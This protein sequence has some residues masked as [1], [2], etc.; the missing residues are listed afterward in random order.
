MALK[1]E[2]TKYSIFGKYDFLEATPENISKL[3]EIFGKE[4]FLPNMV[5]MIQIEQP[6]NIVKQVARP[7]FIN[8]AL[9]CSI[10]FL[11]DRIDIEEKG[12]LS[13]DQVVDY[14]NQ[15]IIAFELKIQRLAMNTGAMWSNLNSEDMEKLKKSFVASQAYPYVNDLIEWSSRNV[16]RQHWKGSIDEQINVGQNIQNIVEIV[17]GV[18]SSSQVRV[19]TDINTLGENTE[20]RFDSKLCK[21]FYQNANVW[22]QALLENLKGII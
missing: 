15:I 4:Q 21:E 16:S 7:Q 13:L 17:N 14:F 9:N 18:V 5:Q 10:T 19:D 20:E 22:N 11:P 12:K 2:S 1:I 3:Y 8:S 6:K